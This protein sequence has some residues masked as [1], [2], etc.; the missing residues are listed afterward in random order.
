VTE[1]S[2]KQIEAELP[3]LVRRAELGRIVPLA[4]TTIYDMDCKGQFPRRFSLTPRCVVWD[5]GEMEAWRLAR[6][7]ASVDGL[8]RSPPQ[9]DVR[10]RRSRPVKLRLPNPSCRGCYPPRDKTDKSALH[11]EQTSASALTADAAA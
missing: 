6:R 5:L 2:R 10:L 7:K 8:I 3:R 9:P 4:D 1:T 11:R